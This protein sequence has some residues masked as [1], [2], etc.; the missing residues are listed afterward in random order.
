MI[1]ILADPPSRSRPGNLP[2]ARNGT[3]VR[4]SGLG[5]SVRPSQD[6]WPALYGEGGDGQQGLWPDL[7]GAEAGIRARPV[8]KLFARP[9]TVWNRRKHIKLIGPNAGNAP[10]TLAIMGAC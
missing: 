3:P 10:L 2:R 7:D 6:E 5:L 9:T 8:R 4:L 1:A